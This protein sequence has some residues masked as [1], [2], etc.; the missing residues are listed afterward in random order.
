M[1]RGAMLR[2]LL[3]IALAATLGG[4][5]NM[6]FFGSRDAKTEGAAA[7]PQVALYQFDVVAPEPLDKLLEP[8]STSRAFA[9]RREATR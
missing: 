1:I 8:T 2:A 3:C 6:P 4:C 7:E 9:R 5:A